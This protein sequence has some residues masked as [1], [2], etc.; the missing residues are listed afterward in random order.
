MAAINRLDNANALNLGTAWSGGVA[1]GTGDVAT[2]SAIVTNISTALGTGGASWGGIALASGQ[3]SN[4]SV[5]TTTAT[6]TIGA[7]GVDLSASGANLTIASPVTIALGANQTWTVGSGRTLTTTSLI[8]GAAK[9]V[10]FAGDGTK[11]LSGNST[12]WTGSTATVSGGLVTAAAV[13]AL[14]TAT[15]S[16]VVQSGGAAR[17]NL[18]TPAMTTFAAAGQ[19]NALQAGAVFF[20]VANGFASGK[21]LTLSG[22]SP[23]ILLLPNTQA[24]VIAGTPTGDVT[25]N[26]TTTGSSGATLSSAQ[27]FTVAS[28]SYLV[29]QGANS[30][31]GAAAQADFGLATSDANPFGAAG[32]A[33]KVRSSLRLTNLGA[34]TA[35]T[36][37]RNYFFDGESTNAA[38]VSPN[39][40]NIAPNAASG[41]SF[42]FTGTITGTAGNWVKT[43]ANGGTTAHFVQF[44]NT[45]AG[46]LDGS[47]NLRSFS[48]SQTIRFHSNL[49]ISTWTG[50]I[51]VNDVSYGVAPTGA[52][53]WAANNT[54]DNIKGSALTLAHSSLSILAGTVTFTG[55]DDLSTGLT[56]ITTTGSVTFAITAKKLTI[57]GNITATSGALGKSSAAGTLSLAGT[58]TGFTSFTHQ[59]GVLEL[60][61]A[62]SAGPSGA[63][64]TLTAVSANTLDSTTGAT[65][66]QS[67]NIALNGD[68]TWGGSGDLTFGSGATAWSAARTISFLNGKTGKLKFPGNIGALISTLSLAVGGSPVGGSRSRLWLAGTNG[69]LATSNNVTAGYFRVSDSAGLGNAVTTTWTVSSGAALE[70]DGGISPTSAR[71]A[72]IA[73]RGPDTDGALRSVSGTNVW[74]GAIAVPVQSLASPTRIQVDAGTFTL[75]AGTYTTIAPSVSST[76]LQFTAL[77]ATAVLNQPR[78]L[79]SAV[80][81][82]TVNNGGVGTVVFS[83][84]N[85]H[86]GGFTVEGGT[87]KVTNATATSTGTVQVNATATL[88]STVQSQFTTLRLGTNGSGSRAILKFAA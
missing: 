53:T 35:I 45:G 31:T 58:N 64:F 62:G 26:I 27:T 40:Y 9:N 73:G 34:A 85:S 81:D 28:G 23:T 22:A 84:A 47:W 69:M 51:D 59:G 16:L 5:G 7:S 12:G 87:A 32:N 37:S 3:T 86:T 33:V 75:A 11:A 78:Q 24:G 21:T 61:S 72:S 67:G 79:T 15:N 30:T 13:N 6:L 83:V 38:P 60:N 46:K 68:F 42:T 71:N 65:L 41:S 80:G 39:T 44:G 49:D 18:S 43:N 52:A 88:E 77:G 17:F 55:T 25:F 14:G 82:V 8:T 70:L 29:L 54:V 57:P 48:S 20:N 66:T 1:P 63:T 4:I 36:L 2:W 10:I 74:N 56:P 19:G 50:A 76:P